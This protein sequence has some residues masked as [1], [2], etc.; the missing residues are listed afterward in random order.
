MKSKRYNTVKFGLLM[1]LIGPVIGFIIYGLYWSWNFQ[2]T[3]AY[4]VNDLFIGT[5]D[6]RSSILSLSLLMNL[7]PFFVFLK[8][9]RFKGARGVMLAVFLYVPFVLYFKFT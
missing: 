7:V 5:P 3:F 1:G 6:L 8:T 9:D 2:K 4:F